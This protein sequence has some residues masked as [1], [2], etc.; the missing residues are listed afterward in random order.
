MGLSYTGIN[1][2]LTAKVNGCNLVPE[3]PANIIPFINFNF[4]ILNF[5]FN[6][7]IEIKLNIYIIEISFLNF[8]YNMEFLNYRLILFYFYLIMKK[9]GLF[10]GVGY[11][12]DGMPFTWQL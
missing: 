7:N 10:A 6:Q 11:E 3:P 8:L 1:C 2:L 5:D 9:L 12:E 4:S